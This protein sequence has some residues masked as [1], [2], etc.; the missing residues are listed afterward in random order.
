MAVTSVGHFADRLCEAITRKGNNIVVGGTLDATNRKLSLSAAGAALAVS[1]TL[2]TTGGTVVYNGT[3][4]QTAAAITYNNVTFNNSA[5]VTAGGDTTVNGTATFTYSWTVGSHTV[6]LSGP[7]TGSGSI[8]ASS[9]S[10]VIP[11]CQD[12]CR[13]T[14]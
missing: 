8:L 11:P 7:V 14:E 10:A 2:I 13:L 4:P 6:T 5:G 9:P 1:G 12:S 3:F